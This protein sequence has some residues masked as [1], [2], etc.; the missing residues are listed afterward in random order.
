MSNPLNGLS[1]LHV[2][3][4][5]VLGM[6]AALGVGAAV[7]A[8]GGGSASTPGGGGQAADLAEGAYEGEKVTLAFWNGFTGGDGAYMKTMVENFNSEHEN[9]EVQMN[10][11]QWSDFYSKVPNAV[12]SGAGPDV[13]AIHVD[14]VGT[15][16]ARRVIMPLD[17]FVSAMDLEEGDFNPTVWN[18]GIYDDQRFAIPL[19]VHPLGQYHNVAL[20]Q[21]AGITEAPQDRE[22][23][24]AALVALQQSGVAQPFWASATFPAHLIWDSLLY[25]FGGTLYDEE[26]AKATFAS[27]AGVEALEWYTSNI[28]KGFSPRNVSVDAELQAF[29]QGRN[30]VTWNG[31]WQILTF[32]GVE[33][34]QFATTPV[35]QIGDT[36]AVWASSH[37]LVVMQQREADENK[38]HAARDFLG[39]LSENSLEWAKGGQI[40][41]RN[42]VRESAE[43]AALEGQSALAE[44]L[45]RVFFPPTVP[46]IG[47]VTAPTWEQA[48]NEVVLGKSD[49]KTALDEA[50][51]KAD[52]LLEDNR[53]KYQA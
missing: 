9:I 5:G 7:S 53:Q 31:I 1:S 3:R 12:A 39:W 43:F 20:A 17:D 25:Q 45:D 2:S 11:L 32:D 18:A 42:S 41:A 50:A 52:A 47:D 19:D 21:K 26:G 23:F 49:A 10:T 24:E 4:R 27:E 48:V 38:L 13:A 35:P 33:G 22:S 51:R 34:L 46:G 40:P 14:Q 30:A 8:C 37:Q 15:Q 6:G 29:Q 44:Q 16:A 36:P 28:T